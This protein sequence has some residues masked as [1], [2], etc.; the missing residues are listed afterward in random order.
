MQVGKIDL[1]EP[2]LDA[3][4]RGDLVVF[5]GAGV[6][7]APPSNYP[8]LKELAAKIG[9]EAS[10]NPQQGEP[11]S[12][13]LGRLR[14]EGVTVHQKPGKGLGKAIPAEAGGAFRQVRPHLERSTG[15]GRSVA[16]RCQG[17]ILANKGPVEVARAEVPGEGRR[18]GGRGE[19]E[20]DPSFLSCPSCSG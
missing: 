3:Q 16:E 14:D 11:L 7:V 17:R 6:S 9:Q 18:A 20:I 1:P 4:L 13:F 19:G 2:L 10:L 12:R 5:A 8:Q 15:A